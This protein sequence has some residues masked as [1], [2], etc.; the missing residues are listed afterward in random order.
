MN[1]VKQ[2]VN[3]IAIY[4]RLSS[5]DNDDVESESIQNQRK[6]I[7]DFIKKNFE[8]QNLYEY[9]DDGY[10]GSNFNRP[11]FKKMIRELKEKQINLIITK[12]LARFARNYIDSGE[13]IEKRFPDMGIRY[14]AVLDGVDSF[15]DKLENDFA[16][17]K[18]LF[19]EMYCRETSKNIRRS[20]KKKREEGYYSC[21]V[22]PY[23]YKKDPN[24]PGKLIIDEAVANVVKQIFLMKYNG[25]TSK[26]IAKYLNEKNILTPA[27]YMNIFKNK[28]IDIWTGEGVSRLVCKPV[29]VGDTYMGKSTNLNYKSKKKI[30][31][32]RIDCTIT[33][34]THEPII[35]REIFDAIHNN[36]KYNNYKE[37]IPNVET[38]LGDY[39]YCYQC[40]RKLRKV[41]KNGKI[42]LFC[43]AYLSSDSLCTNS[44]RYSYNDVEKTIIDEIRKD[45]GNFLNSRYSKQ[46]IYKN[47]RDTQ[48]KPILQQKTIIEKEKN[49]IMFKISAL[50]NDRLEH[51]INE[52][53]YKN[54]YKEL[55]NERNKLDKQLEDILKNEQMADNES[56]I[57]KNI[58]RIRKI[59]KKMDINKFEKEDFKFLINK[60]ELGDDIIEIDFKFKE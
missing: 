51:K 32:K 39:M 15:E 59:Y 31:N 5:E 46:N 10:S 55:I 9:I 52:E 33:K 13:Y 35:S 28:K 6:I 17:F 54:Y 34:N 41:N 11:S 53:Q 23:G 8:Y 49:K 44:K 58:K 48:I 42:F 47:Y 50:Y 16:P 14:I 12:N 19:N 27:R 60:I 3:N 1:I 43:G 7:Y 25:K 30:N 36:N 22:P 57:K 20:K 21:P 38:K 24:N 45:V 40:K 2:E 37:K 26:E 18:G 29:Y 4:L 56:E